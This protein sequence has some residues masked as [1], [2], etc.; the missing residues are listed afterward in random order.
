MAEVFGRENHVATIPYRTNTNQSTRLLPEV[1]N[2]LIWFG[3]DK[4]ATKYTNTPLPVSLPSIP[5][6][7]EGRQ[8]K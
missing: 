5:T 7:H 8:P 2:W 3:K 1:G 4:I 6:R